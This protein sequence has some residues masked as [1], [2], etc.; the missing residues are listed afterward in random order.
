MC[1]SP[2]FLRLSPKF[3]FHSAGLHILFLPLEGSGSSGGML[4]SA[5][6]AKSWVLVYKK[7]KVSCSCG[8]LAEGGR[9][10]VG[11]ARLSV[12]SRDA[13]GVRSLARW[14]LG[15]SYDS[16]PS[17]SSSSLREGHEGSTDN[18]IWVDFLPYCGVHYDFYSASHHSRKVG[19]DNGIKISISAGVS[20]PSLW[21]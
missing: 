8:E 17:R 19:E 14:L 15:G 16:G 21:L 20:L 11:S 9:V 7:G 10:S 2:I 3:F 4:L 18:F 6:M 5:I 1:A 13:H 12:M